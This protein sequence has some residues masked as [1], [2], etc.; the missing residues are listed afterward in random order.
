MYELIYTY[1][2]ILCSI[3]DIADGFR[4]DDRFVRMFEFRKMF[5]RFSHSIYVLYDIYIFEKVTHDMPISL[6][7]ISLV[8]SRCSFRCYD[9]IHPRSRF[10]IGCCMNTFCAI[11]LYIYFHSIVRVSEIFSKMKITLA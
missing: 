4:T 3:D 6:H 8:Q 5:T 9:F 2:H 1:I 7:T 10:I 11:F